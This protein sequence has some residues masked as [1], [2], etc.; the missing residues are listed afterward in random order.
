MTPDGIPR[1]KN[2][3]QNMLT[4]F[5]RPTRIVPNNTKNVSQKKCYISERGNGIGDRGNRGVPTFFKPMSPNIQ[6]YSITKNNCHSDSSFGYSNSS[7]GKENV[8]IKDFSTNIHVPQ[9]VVTPI[10]PRSINKYN[11]DSDN[12]DSTLINDSDYDVKKGRNRI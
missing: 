11:D 6:D 7:R 1:E 12:N 10:T 3:D 5:N 4:I 2:V 8:R 9:R